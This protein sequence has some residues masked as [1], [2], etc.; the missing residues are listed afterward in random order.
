M[1]ALIHNERRIELCFEGHRF[2]DIRRWKKT[3][4]MK[5][6]VSGVRITLGTPNTYEYFNVE[7]RNYQD[8][9]IYGPIP[10]GEIL[11]YNELVQNLGW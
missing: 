1:R 4:I 10:Y 2:F 7:P 5:A 8:Y 3:E 9:M 6:S 11:K